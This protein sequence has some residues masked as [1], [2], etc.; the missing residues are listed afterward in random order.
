M[1]LLNDGGEGVGD[2]CHDDDD[3]EEKD[4]KGRHDELD[5][6]PS[7]GS[8]LPVLALGCRRFQSDGGCRGLVGCQHLG[9]SGANLWEISLTSHLVDIEAVAIVMFS[10]ARSSS[11]RVHFISS[12][13]EVYLGNTTKTDNQK[14]NQLCY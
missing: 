6:P 2:D 7:D 10:P 13:T 11:C 4:E 5:V 1:K 9:R 8:V 14:D 3:G 12:N